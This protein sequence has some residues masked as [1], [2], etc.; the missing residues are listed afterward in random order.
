MAATICYQ[1]N[2]KKSLIF[3]S[4]KGTYFLNG[5]EGVGYYRSLSTSQMLP[6]TVEEYKIN[7]DEISRTKRRSKFHES[8]LPK[9]L[10]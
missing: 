3:G 8:S 9:E 7:Y 1:K 5:T 2:F 6:Q 10:L 4:D